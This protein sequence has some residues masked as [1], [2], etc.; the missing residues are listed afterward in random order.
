MESI[1]TVK[2]KLSKKATT[3]FYRAN[4]I[5]LNHN[6]F[7]RVN[8]D[9][10]NR[11]P[12]KFTVPS[13]FEIGYHQSGL[14]TNDRQQLVFVAELEESDCYSIYTC[15]TSGKNMKRLTK[16]I[17]DDIGL[18]AITEDQTI[19]Y[20]RCARKKDSSKELWKIDID[21]NTNTKIDIQIPN[22]DSIKIESIGLLTSDGK[23]NI[24]AVN[25]INTKEQSICKCDINGEHPEII[26]QFLPNEFISAEDITEEGILLFRKII[27][28][29]LPE[30]W[31]NNTGAIAPKQNFS[32]LWAVNLDGTNPHRIH[33]QLPEQFMLNIYNVVKSKDGKLYLGT[34][35]H[36]LLK[37]TIFTCN[38][39][40]SDLKP[41]VSSNQ[42]IAVLS[43]H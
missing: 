12:L 5:Q 42:D 13:P 4:N 15:S 36:S 8:A 7:W 3:I 11:K 14:L 31:K 6:V 26:I 16:V 30:K 25:N 2:R 1:P 17:T 38:L 34:H 19:Y 33:I 18:M 43:A 35:H 24:F 39:D 29:P 20:W 32:E 10:T 28:D 23:T 37:N 40:G 21:G 27:I 41:F 22:I 9:G